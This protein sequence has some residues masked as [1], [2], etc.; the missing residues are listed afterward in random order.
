MQIAVTTSTI[1]DDEGAPSTEVH[2][3]STDSERFV[4]VTNA[5]SVRVATK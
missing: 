1:V 2:K 4:A 5:E 3:Q